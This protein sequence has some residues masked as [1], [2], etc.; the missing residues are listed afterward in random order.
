VRQFGITALQDQV[1]DVAEQ[2][3]GGTA[4]LQIHF[5]EIEVTIF[6]SVPEDAT[7]LQPGTV[8]TMR[9]LKAF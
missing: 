3:P 1:L 4:A 5:K 9:I 7:V 8:N 2:L 6:S